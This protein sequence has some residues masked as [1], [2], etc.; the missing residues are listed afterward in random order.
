[1]IEGHH[2][3]GLDELPEGA[4]ATVVTSHPEF[5]KPI[6]TLPRRGSFEALL[7]LAGDLPVATELTFQIEGTGP[8]GELL[9]TSFHAVVAESVEPE[10]PRKVSEESAGMKGRRAPYILKFVTEPEWKATP[11]WGATEWT[12]EDSGC[13][14]EPTQSNPLVLI[15]NDDCAL[16]RSAREAMLG[17][18]LDE[19]TIKRRVNNYA[20]HIAY[21]LWQMYQHTQNRKALQA[22]DETTPVPDEEQLRG[23]INRVAATLINLMEQELRSAAGRAGL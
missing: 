18:K 3:A 10:S 22:V 16:L 5:P 8:R 14:Q 15:I 6:F 23:E 7:E 13:Y 17:R 20:A 21:H 1:M 4:G 12:L 19:A 11:C 9:S 2:A